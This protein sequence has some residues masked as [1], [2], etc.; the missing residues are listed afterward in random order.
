VADDRLAHRFQ[1]AAD[2]TVAF[3]EA[4][5]HRR[6]LAEQHQPLVFLLRANPIPQEISPADDALGGRQVFAGQAGFLGSEL[7]KY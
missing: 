4:D 7:R 5:R 2:R 6:V 3:G 1:Y